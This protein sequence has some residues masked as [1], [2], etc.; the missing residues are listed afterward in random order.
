MTMSSKVLF[1]VGLLAFTIVCVQA[2][3]TYTHIPGGLKHAT[4]STNYIWGVNLNDQIWRCSR[5][6]TGNWVLVDGAL[7]QIDASDDEV[8][9]VNR[10]DQIFKRPVDG[11]GSWVHIPGGLKHVSASGNG[12]IWGVNT[13]NQIYKCKKPCS[14]HWHQVD[15]HLKQIDGG[16]RYVYGVNNANQVWTRPIDGSGSWRLIRGQ[17]LKHVTASSA[18]SI[19]GVDTADHIYRC[20]KPCVG[21]FEVLDG[22]LMQIDGTFDSFVGVNSAHHIFTR[23]TGV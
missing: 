16:E 14:G 2:V 17:L 7:K 18:T 22:R 10:Y 9:G 4:A 20:E 3:N 5:P 11:S 21:N 6:C 15:G 1:F 8:W 23:K 19:Y 13:H 12:Y